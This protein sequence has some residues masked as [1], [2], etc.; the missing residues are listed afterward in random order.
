MTASKM[1]AL[2][3]LML[4]CIVAV[5]SLVGRKAAAS[6][7]A[8]ASGAGVVKGRQYE[9]PK[10]G[11]ALE[12]PEDWVATE[13]PKLGADAT[14][15]GPVRDDFVM[16]L[17]VRSEVSPVALAIYVDRSIKNRLPGYLSDFELLEE[18]TE[19]INGVDAVRVRYSFRQ[20]DYKVTA[21]SA[22]YGMAERKVT[23]TFTLLT[24]HYDEL[25]PAV[26][27]TIASFKKFAGQ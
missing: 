6:R 26:D 25:K 20:G 21:V 12:Y 2:V 1:A 22:I 8:G 27:Q 23:L 13:K 7:F 11:F 10:L 15:F 18:T 16:G 14:F 4:I 19:T 5:Y 24:E 17:S 9:D 3:V